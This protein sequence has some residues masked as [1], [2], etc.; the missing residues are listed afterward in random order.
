MIGEFIGLGGRWAETEDAGIVGHW[1]V[2]VLL[3]AE[4]A[5]KLGEME[6]FVA[7]LA[8]SEVRDAVQGIADGDGEVKFRLDGPQGQ[9]VREESLALLAATVLQFLGDGSEDFH[10]KKTNKTWGLDVVRET[11]FDHASYLQ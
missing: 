6:R 3:M 7:A 8:E 9:G 11:L 1:L 10:S 2:T 5:P 4:V